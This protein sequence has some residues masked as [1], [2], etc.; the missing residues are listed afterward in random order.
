MMPTER[1][2]MRQ[3]REILRQ[4]WVVGLRHRDVARSLGLGVG[5]VCRVLQRAQTAGLDW[6][7][8][9]A[10]SD[11]ALER[12]IYSAAVAA[13]RADRP[14]PDCGWIHTER[15]K[16]SVT[17]ALLHVEYL[18][19]HPDGYRYTQFCERYRRW[20]ARRH[21]TMR[22][23]HRA[24]EKCFVDYAGQKPTIVEAATGEILAVELFVAALGAS[25]YTYAEATRTQQVPDWIASHQRAF[26]FFGGVPGLS[27]A[28]DNQNY[29]QNPIM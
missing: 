26:Q 11:E 29:Q 23:V 7:Q 5:T 15:S 21:L 9:E 18:A 28:R 14:E 1:L 22:Q 2:S 24:G 25:N 27:P 8:V 4:K 13:A 17:L 10:L 12:Q 16:A 3:I 6:A 20:L 19:Q